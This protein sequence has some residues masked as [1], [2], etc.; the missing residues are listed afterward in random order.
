V[1]ISQDIYTSNSITF[2][3]FNPAPPAAVTTT[4]Y[5]PAGKT[6]NK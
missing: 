2:P 4:N 1:T 6:R 5:R 3:V